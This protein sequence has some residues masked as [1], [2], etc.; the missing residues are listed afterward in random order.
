LQLD[1]ST[2]EPILQRVKELQKI[3]KRLNG[4]AKHPDSII[5]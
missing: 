2:K 3:A 1:A 4:K 5:H